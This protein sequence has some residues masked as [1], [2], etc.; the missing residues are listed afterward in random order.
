V[1]LDFE[2][3]GL[4]TRLLRVRQLSEL[5]SDVRV[6]ATSKLVRYLKKVEANTDGNGRQASKLFFLF[7]GVVTA[8]FVARVF[9]A[10]L[11]SCN[12]RLIYFDAA[13]VV[14]V[15]GEYRSRSHEIGRSRCKQRR[16]DSICTPLVTIS[17]LA[18]DRFHCR[19]RSALAAASI[20]AGAIVARPHIE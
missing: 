19:A 16:R 14:Y 2:I 12:H 4:L 10:T 15:C 5:D 6:E 7:C 1:W 8:Q 20:H 18:A 11:S 3:F 9:D 13:Y 17:A